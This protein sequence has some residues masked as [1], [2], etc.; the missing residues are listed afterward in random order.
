MV[1]NPLGSKGPESDFFTCAVAPLCPLLGKRQHSALEPLHCKH[2]SR[3]VKS[4]K[5]LAI[6]SKVTNSCPWGAN[7]PSGGHVGTNSSFAMFLSKSGMYGES[8]S[9]L[10]CRFVVLQFAYGPT[11]LPDW[12]V[13]E[14]NIAN[15][16]C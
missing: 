4:F 7:G 13:E 3:A 15:G 16:S 12:E 10:T 9:Y 1:S 11:G 5:R 8:I 14:N 6:P 2:T